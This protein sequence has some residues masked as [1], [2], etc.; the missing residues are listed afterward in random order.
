MTKTQIFVIDGEETTEEKSSTRRNGSIV[1][2]S[3]NGNI[4]YWSG[5]HIFTIV[6]CCGSLMSILT[7]IPRHNSIID[8][9]FWF[10]ISAV[11]AITWLLATAVMVMDF[12]IMFS[13]RSLVS[14]RF[15]LK[16]YMA[17]FLTWLI[18]FCT[19]YMIWTMILENSHPMPWIGLIVYLTTKIVSVVSLPLMLPREFSS[20]QESNQKLRIFVWYQLSILL[21]SFLKILQLFS[22]EEDRL[23]S[24]VW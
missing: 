19:S 24:P 9:S 17:C 2:K 22:L 10:E 5:L 11:A 16:N 14:I 18:C 21:A 23:L 8:Q 15:F 3:Y 13:N 7:L 20:D 6:C 1:R 12:T 4:N